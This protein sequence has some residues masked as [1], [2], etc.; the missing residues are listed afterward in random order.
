MKQLWRFDSMIL[1]HLD[2]H[3][4]LENHS[5]QCT[6]IAEQVSVR[7]ASNYKKSHVKCLHADD[8]MRKSERSLTAD[9]LN[10]FK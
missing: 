5:E 9:T 2:D 4:S 6:G 7:L 8:F 1:R 10:I 3:L